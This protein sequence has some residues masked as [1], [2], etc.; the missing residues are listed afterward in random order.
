MTNECGDLSSNSIV[1]L[2]SPLPPLL[3]F[4]FGAGVITGALI[5]DDKRFGTI[6]ARRA[7]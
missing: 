3:F 6:C 7:S 2:P 5:D 1:E 4:L